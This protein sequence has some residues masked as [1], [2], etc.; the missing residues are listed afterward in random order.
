MKNYYFLS[1]SLP[2]IAIGEKV[3]ISF[4]ELLFRLKINLSKKDWEQVVVFRR[5]LDINNIRAL[6]LEDSIDLRG[7]LDEQELDAA[8][9]LQFHLPD[10]VFDFLGRFEQIADKIK[11]FPQLLSLYFVQENEKAHGFLKDYLQWEREWRLVLAAIR[12]KLLGRNIVE[13]FQME[14]PFDPFIIDIIAQKDAPVYEPPTKYCDLKEIFLSQKIDLWQKNKAIASWRLDQIGNLV[15]KPLFSIEWILS[16]MAQ[17]LIVEQWNEFD[18]L[19]GSNILE[20][21]IG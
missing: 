6:F 17:L 14:D 16:Y 11:F 12:A 8:L 9:L 21:F 5:F 18:E 4:E 20:A 19:K 2:P 15:K 13:E 10:Y 3:N 1:V 7:N